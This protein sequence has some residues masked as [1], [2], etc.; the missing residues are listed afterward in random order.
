MAASGGDGGDGAATLPKMTGGGG[1]LATRRNGARRH[2]RTRERGQ[3]KEENT[4]KVYMSSNRRDQA[5]NERNRF[6]KSTDSVLETNSKTNSNRIQ[7]SMIFFDSW[8]KRKR[9][10]RGTKPL[11][12]SEESG[13]DLDEFERR[14]GGS[15]SAW[16]R[17]AGGRRR[18]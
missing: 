5:A 3:T 8:G 14:K 4:R 10:S 1:G 13:S 15:D 17:P 2:E 6:G 9:R 7:T 11:N 12:Q 18:A 16:R